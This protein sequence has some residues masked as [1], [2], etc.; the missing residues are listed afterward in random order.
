M[1]SLCQTLLKYC[2]LQSC[3][4]HGKHTD[5]YAYEYVNRTAIPFGHAENSAHMACEDVLSFCTPTNSC[6]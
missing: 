4:Q 2:R 1:Y 3:M 6:L 5:T